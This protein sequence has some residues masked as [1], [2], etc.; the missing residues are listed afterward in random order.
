MF[1]NIGQDIKIFCALFIHNFLLCKINLSMISSEK[2]YELIHTVTQEISVNYYQKSIPDKLHFADLRNYLDSLVINWKPLLAEHLQQKIDDI[3]QYELSNQGVIL[4]NSLPKYKNTNI[5]LGI[6]DICLVSTDCII[7]NINSK[8]NTKVILK[9]GPRMKN[10][11]ANIT[12]ANPNQDVITTLGYNLPS[13]HIIHI[14]NYSNLNKIFGQV[15]N[16]LKRSVA[17]KVNINN[18]DLILNQCKNYKGDMEIVLCIDN[19]IRTLI[20]NKLNT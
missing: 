17:I 2:Y 6:I 20:I 12:K 9:A 4:W 15:Q 3:L 1:K 13:R 11:Y 5:R 8:M 14:K 7:N 18:I 19:N 16:M 10:E